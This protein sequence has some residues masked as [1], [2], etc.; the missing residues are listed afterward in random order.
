MIT[1]THYR[2]FNTISSAGPDMKMRM[3]ELLM[4]MLILSLHYHLFNNMITDDHLYS[5]SSVQYYLFCR[6]GDEEDEDDGTA[7][8]ISFSKRMFSLLPDNNEHCS[9]VDMKLGYGIFVSYAQRKYLAGR[10]GHLQ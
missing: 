2:L 8:R 9:K 10:V 4:G 5:T 1:F 7:D 3:M 6:A